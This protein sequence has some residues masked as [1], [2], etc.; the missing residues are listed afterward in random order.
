MN[1]VKVK[2]QYSIHEKKTNTGYKMEYCIVV[3]LA[4]DSETVTE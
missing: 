3:F 1:R 4:S 2:K